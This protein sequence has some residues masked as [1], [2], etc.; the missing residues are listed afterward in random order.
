MCL[1]WCQFTV[2]CKPRTLNDGG[3]DSVQYRTWVHKTQ[4]TQVYT[5]H[6]IISLSLTSQTIIRILCSSL[7]PSHQWPHLPAGGSTK[8]S[9]Q[10]RQEWLRQAKQCYN[11]D[12]R[13][14][15]GYASW[16][17]KDHQTGCF[18]QSTWG[19]PLHSSSKSAAPG[20]SS[21]QENP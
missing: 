18:P 9:S 13:T 5:G 12:E 3:K 7:G 4:L 6:K 16:Q 19:S 20:H 21:N 10:V 8:K 11:H 14:W 2:I 15:L 17:K 1:H